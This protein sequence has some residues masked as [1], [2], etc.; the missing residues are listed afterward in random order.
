MQ[1][2]FS[3]HNSLVRATAATYEIRRGATLIATDT[4]DQNANSGRWVRIQVGQT[5]SWDSDDLAPLSLSVTGSS[6]PA[7]GDITADQVRFTKT[8]DLSV[9]STP[10]Y[11][12][13]FV[14]V[15]ATTIER[16]VVIVT[17]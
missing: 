4:I 1:S 16:D 15:G 7:T 9:T 12:R 10:V 3:F 17:T 5:N 8:A 6:N 13:A 2:K 11:T 14:R